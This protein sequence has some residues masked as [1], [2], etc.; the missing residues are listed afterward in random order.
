[1]VALRRAVR[2]IG[3][4]LARQLDGGLHAAG[5]RAQQAP[6]AMHPRR[7][8]ASAQAIDEYLKELLT[9]SAQ[10]HAKKEPFEELLAQ[11]QSGA[12]SEGMQQRSTMR[13]T[14]RLSASACASSRAAR[15]GP[16]QLLRRRLPPSPLLLPCRR[17]CGGHALVPRV[18]RR[19]PAHAGLQRARDA[20]PPGGM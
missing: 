3:Q 13:P 15:G 18:P 14:A 10:K 8:L 2:L 12:R 5:P 17:V 11:I 6:H 9:L 20:G 4:F 1:M 16:L 7:A 19:V